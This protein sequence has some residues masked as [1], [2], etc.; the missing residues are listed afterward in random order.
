MCFLA[1]KA[2]GTGAVNG[3]VAALAKGV[4]RAMFLTRLKAAALAILTV[5]VV[6][7]GAGVLARGGQKESPRPERR[8]DEAAATDR[9]TIHSLERRI[10]EL[11]RKLDVVLNA[12]ET[13]GA[14]RPEPSVPDPGRKIRPRFECLVEAVHVKLGQAVKKGEP[15]AEL[16]SA[17]LSQA[18]SDLQHRWLQWQ[19]ELLLYNSQKKLAA[20]H[21]ISQVELANAQNDEQ[22][23]RLDFTLARDK[24]AVFFEVPQEEI[25]ESLKGLSDARRREVPS[26]PNAAIEAIRQERSAAGRNARFTLR[27][28]VDG[29]VAAVNVEPQDM[30]DPKTVLMVIRKP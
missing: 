21:S 27:S 23:S 29:T 10:T 2:A 24:L 16:F 19:H 20:N 18:R 26:G 25:D 22:K 7:V 12:M 4:M 1:G 9:E 11:E 5:A 17:E 6:G 30:A 8:A 3:S 28:P 15:L 14:R 13:P